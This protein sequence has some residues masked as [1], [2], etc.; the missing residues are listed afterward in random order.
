MN[1]IAASRP[2]N[3][4][5]SEMRESVWRKEHASHRGEPPQF[6]GH[7]R[8]PGPGLKSNAPTRWPVITGKLPAARPQDS[9]QTSSVC[10][11]C[12]SFSGNI[13]PS[14]TL[15]FISLIRLIRE[16]HRTSA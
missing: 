13:L 2:G 6:G 11:T 14:I 7:T 10:A 4:L 8:S 12:A 9:F 15:L 3:V 1:G 16:T 5:Q